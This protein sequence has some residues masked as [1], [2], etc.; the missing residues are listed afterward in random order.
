PPAPG[1]SPWARRSA[2][3]AVCRVKQLLAIRTRARWTQWPAGRAWRKDSAGTNTGR[4]S[5][6]YADVA[7]LAFAGKLR[8]LLPL[9]EPLQLLVG[10]RAM[11]MRA[12]DTFFVQF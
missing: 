7:L 1:R 5:H 4:V 12:A 2:K 6:T 11:T 9:A 8:L 10:V 3:P